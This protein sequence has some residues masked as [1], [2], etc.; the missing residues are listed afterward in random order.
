MHCNPALAAVAKILLQAFV[1]RA[2][3][4]PKMRTIIDITETF[5]LNL[6]VNFISP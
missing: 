1:K 2:R 5:Q 6:T 4:N 3:M